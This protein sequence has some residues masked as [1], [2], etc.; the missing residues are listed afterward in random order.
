MSIYLKSR[1]HPL[2]IGEKHIPLNR[3]D[4]CDFTH[5]L[6]TGVAANCADCSYLTGGSGWESAGSARSFYGMYAQ[7]FGISSPGD[8][9]LERDD[10]G[11]LWN[12]GFGSS[13]PSVCQFAIGD[14]SVQSLSVTTDQNL[15]AALALVDDGKAVALP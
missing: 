6:V 1:L 11:P 9:L 8:K 10:Y 14:G 15:L 7:R 12:Y 3:L 13:H 5:T 4:K 2:I